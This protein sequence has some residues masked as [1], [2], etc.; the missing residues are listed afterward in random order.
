M[1]FSFIPLLLS[2]SSKT[3]HRE[4]TWE[5]MP[6]E[7]EPTKGRKRRKKLKWTEASKRLKYKKTR[8]LEKILDLQMLLG[9]KEIEWNWGK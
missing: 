1:P 2:N 6:T 3:I 5:M 4:R 8:S 9:V 7:S